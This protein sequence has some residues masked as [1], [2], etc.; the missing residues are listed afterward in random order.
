[1]NDF[2]DYDPYDVELSGSQGASGHEEHL[3][4]SPARSSR[5]RRRS[6][7]HGS[8]DASVDAD[9]LAGLGSQQLDAS[10]AYGYDQQHGTTAEAGG[11]SLADELGGLSGGNDGSVDP[12]HDASTLAD[13]MNRLNTTTSTVAPKAL[14]SDLNDGLPSSSSAAAP[15]SS[16]DSAY[17]AAPATTSASSSYDDDIAEARARQQE[18]SLQDLSKSIAE[19]VAHTDEFLAKL[20]AGDEDGQAPVA[21]TATASSSSSSRPSSAAARDISHL[22]SLG[23]SLGLSLRE[24]AEL[25]VNQ[26][27]ELRDIERALSRD[28]PALWMALAHVVGS[29]AAAAAHESY[30]VNGDGPDG[31]QAMALDL[32]RDLT[33]P[34][35]QDVLGYSRDPVSAPSTSCSSAGPSPSSPLHAHL[36]HLSSLTASLTTSLRSI[37]E[38]LQVSAASSREAAKRL[39]S[40]RKAVEEARREAEETER[41]SRAIEAE[42]SETTEGVGESRRRKSEA[43]RR[44][45]DEVRKAFERAEGLVKEKGWGRTWIE[46]ELMDDRLEKLPKESWGKGYLRVVDQHPAVAGLV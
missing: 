24:Q 11:L 2:E 39:R 45:M 33:P 4:D 16:Q 38:T 14:A 19:S 6:N 37:S 36:T 41:A 44:E 13:E 15:S 26:T 35:A 8:H 10:H 28:D 40:L 34:A 22:E 1:M 30:Q 9:E 12:S 42:R 46:S 20:R 29:A 31:L 7:D 21:S 32:D 27:R 25:R 5:R 17:T 43:I 3:D 23:H 18:A